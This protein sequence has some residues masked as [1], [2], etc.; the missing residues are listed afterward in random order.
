[1]LFIGPYRISVPTRNYRIILLAASGL[2][3][4]AQLPY[5]KQLIHSYNTYQTYTRRIYLV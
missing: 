3:I 2:G 5:L 4:V 1:S